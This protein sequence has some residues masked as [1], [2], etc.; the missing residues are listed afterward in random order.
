[1]DKS[2]FP[3]NRTFRVFV[4]STFSDMIVE[5]NALQE[6]VFPRLRDLCLQFGAGFQAVDLRWGI[7]EQASLEQQTMSIC[8]GEI[9]RSQ[10]LSPRP[11]FIILLGDR[12]GWQPLPDE[13][14]AEEFI[15]I[16]ARLS[17]QEA[18]QLLHTWYR[19]D[20][21][22]V[23]PVYV[24]QPR[25]G[26]LAD[27][28]VWKRE[29]ER[30]LRAY[31]RQAVA[32]LS[33][34]PP[35]IQK[36]TASATEQ[37]IYRG[38][39][40]VSDSCE[41]VY[42][43]CRTIE[44]LPSDSSASDYI[45]L[46]PEGQPDENAGRKQAE[47]KAQL[48]SALP[49]NIF[50]AHPIWNQ[51]GH[52]T[53]YLDEF[54]KF[55]YEHLADVIQE[56]IRKAGAVDPLRKEIDGHLTFAKERAHGFL[57]R[58]DALDWVIRNVE[59]W[60]RNLLVVCG[61]SGSGKSALLAHARAVLGDAQPETDFISRWIGATPAST[62]PRLLLEGLCREISKTFDFEAQKKARL[63][64]ALG[65]SHELR[66]ERRKIEE[67]YEIPDDMLHLAPRFREFLGKVPDGR[68]VVLI[69][70]AL[71]QLEGLSA[72]DLAA[73]VPES[74]PPNVCLLIS[75][76]VGDYTSYLQTQLPSGNIWTLEPLPVADAQSLLDSWL[77]EV[78]RTL[79]TEQR[80]E[81]LNGFGACGLPLYLRLAFEEARR[82]RSYDR[83]RPLGQSVS[84][85]LDN[86]F[87]RLSSDLNHGR[88]FVARSLGYLAVSKEGLGE[89]ELL[90]V[91]SNDKEVMTDFRRR[92]PQSPL[93]ERLPIVVWSR[94]LGE[95]DPY[96]MRRHVDGKIVLSF[97]HR[98]LRERVGAA[99]LSGAEA[100]A[101]HGALA[102]YF[103]SQPLEF[104]RNGQRCPNRRR[105]S[106]LP[107]QLVQAGLS[108]ELV[109]LLT[110][111]SVLHSRCVAG[112]V[113]ALIG[114][115]NL[116]LRRHSHASSPEARK[117]EEGLRLIR[118]ALRSAAHLVEDPEQLATQLQGR[119]VGVDAPEVVHLLESIGAHASGPWI[120][121][122]A[123]AFE[124]AD[125]PL[126][127]VLR[128]PDKTSFNT[129]FVA[130][131]PER[132]TPVCV[133]G[134]PFFDTLVLWDLES[135]AER[136]KIKVG[137]AQYALAMFADGR[138]FLTCN[139]VGEVK[140]WDMQ[141]GSVQATF[142][143]GGKVTAAQISHDDRCAILAVDKNLQSGGEPEIE[144]WELDHDSLTLSL[145]GKYFI[146]SAPG[147]LA[148]TLDDRRLLFVSEDGIRQWD[149]EQNKELP[150][151]S[152][153]SAV[154]AYSA[155]NRLDSAFGDDLT[156]VA[157]FPDGKNAVS[158]SQS[159][160]VM[161]WNLDTGAPM[162]VV[163]ELDGPVENLAVA[164]DGRTLFAAAYNLVYAWDLVSKRSF[165]PFHG[166]TQGVTDLTITPD[167]RFAISASYDGSI[168]IWD[169]GAIDDQRTVP[170]HYYPHK[171]QIL[172][173]GLA[174]VTFSDSE[175]KVWDLKRFAESVSIKGDFAAAAVT[176]DGNFAVSQSE[177]T[178]DLVV[179]DLTVGRVTRRFHGPDECLVDLAVS[180]DGR[181]IIGLTETTLW[182]W[183][184][185]T[186]RKLSCEQDPCMNNS[187][188]L[189]LTPDGLYVVV[190]TVDHG[191]S[192]TELGTG[193]R[194]IA[195]SPNEIGDTTHIAITPDG[196]L[197]MTAAA[198]VLSFWDDTLELWEMAQGVKG[199]HKLGQWK[200]ITDLAVTPDRRYALIACEGEP[201]AVYDIRR[202]QV[203][204]RFSG[205]SNIERC[206]V[207]PDGSVIMAQDQSGKIYFLKLE[208][209]E[210]GPSIVT[211][212]RAPVPAWKILGS[213]KRQPV[214]LLCPYCH[215]WF[216]V[217]N[218]CLGT[219]LGCPGCHTVLR[220][221]SFFVR[222]DWRA[223]SG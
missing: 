15:Q 8:L 10:R 138:R 91:L 160:I 191:M 71:D 185:L 156:C 56:E 112:G 140:I 171:L 118:R 221:N 201:F 53:E 133:L 85:I 94:L 124:S 95:I 65:E 195:M 21:N 132:T 187:K 134:G 192:F 105:L 75:T 63:Q 99:L 167:S 11:N 98:Q 110:D 39:L 17:T 162:E 208:N 106:E 52:D 158:G 20:D 33:F 100:P 217:P 61:P 164:P 193:L 173:D 16:D 78:D 189:T 43:F 88:I 107:Y 54:C 204:L 51:D 198:D 74:L 139:I 37:E 32:D 46:D 178:D 220:L 103:A 19:R 157:A 104:E 172:R 76:T 200:K 150:T 215:R 28:E 101:R 136:A 183:D 64:S 143:S 7:S 97:F 146:G 66:E 58:A 87:E 182:L 68:K 35:I 5:R 214:G 126:W 127:G 45:D 121:S 165:G 57:G 3:Q 26:K 207:T 102:Q 18:E 129:T 108:K 174:G 223:I 9:Q 1:V 179:W 194:S 219:D 186:G 148:L 14:P 206:A 154:V 44:G 115:Y 125:S 216:E 209:L 36:Y 70:D 137:D 168:F 119:L 205:E 144:V 222:G 2:V 49:G 29:V 211:A 213:A 122:L 67:E 96:L 212:W 210:Q 113:Q 202:S 84:G 47:L 180:I 131:T 142:R 77:R 6:R 25:T 23:P 155:T 80:T 83:M 123:P 4:S 169:I 203:V 197:A 218:A 176:P 128:R 175:L 199:R 38:A 190:G 69:V 141:S 30:P 170:Y 72:A 196:K 27:Y 114:D 60:N 79:S 93:S 31:L 24:L 130:V 117:S 159:G 145:P 166:H 12:Y 81:V 135:G 34:T 147:A 59:T 177:E 86:L 184:F 149:L 116:A 161:T 42:A 89:D 22:A 153:T 152:K 92:S 181:I 40:T 188:A 111:F 90:D 73:F 50:S 13:I 120:R 55:M 62:E 151:L 41:H 48:Q 109:N 163:A 82:W